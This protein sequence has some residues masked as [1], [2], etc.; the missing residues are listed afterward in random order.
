MALQGVVL[1][2]IQ[3]TDATI[4]HFG[5]GKVVMTF[6]IVVSVLIFLF[7]LVILSKNTAVFRDKEPKTT[8]TNDTLSTQARPSSGP[9][10]LRA[11]TVS[12]QK[13]SHVFT[14]RMR[15]IDG[16]VVHAFQ[17]SDNT[18]LDHDASVDMSRCDQ[19]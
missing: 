10:I 8:S 13:V 9:V 5:T 1:R 14:G 17:C 16:A 2:K 11:S 15:N 7:Y 18:A 12:N 19:L 3:V 6:A 4:R